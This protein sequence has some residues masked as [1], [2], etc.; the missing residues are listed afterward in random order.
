MNSQNPVR[1][2]AVVC[3]YQNPG[4]LESAIRSLL[5]QDLPPDEYEIIVVDNNSQDETPRVVERLGCNRSPPVRYVQETRQGLSHARNRGVK[6]ALADIVAFLDDDAEAERGWL[7]G[8]LEAYGKH[9][10]IWAVGGRIL[11]IW[12]TCERP[13]WWTEDYLAWLSLIDWG[14]APRALT[15]PERIL[16]TNCSFRKSVFREFGYFDPRLGRRGKALLGHEETEIQQ[17]IHLENK[18]VFYTPDSVVRHHVPAERLSEEYILRRQ[19]G[20]ARSK[21]AL[22]RK[23]QGYRPAVL[24]AVA[25]GRRLGRVSLVLAAGVLNRRR[26]TDFE[27]KRMVYESCGLIAGLA[28]DLF[29]FDS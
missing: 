16:G 14:D 18:V 1:V 21:M 13:E 25:A 28:E 23:R 26:Q 7:S 29:S 22:I 27:D 11:P 15:W 20:A 4:L 19:F 3:T 2:S 24:E 10:D 12:H 5:E 8:L 17:R 9:P 6:A